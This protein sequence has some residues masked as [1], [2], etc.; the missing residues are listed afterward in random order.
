M[1]KKE[2]AEAD[3]CVRRYQFAVTAAWSTLDF[4]L[5]RLAYSTVTD[6]ARFLG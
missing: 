3:R 2:E 5:E 1:T 4:K 6:F